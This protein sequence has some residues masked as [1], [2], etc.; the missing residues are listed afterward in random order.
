MS[1]G[2]SRWL[3]LLGNIVGVTDA[4][5]WLRANRRFL[6]PSLPDPISVFDQYQ[7]PHRRAFAFRL[8]LYFGGFPSSFTGHSACRALLCLLAVDNRS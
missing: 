5:T 8:S 4:L 3:F 7:T 6:R 2:S 1:D